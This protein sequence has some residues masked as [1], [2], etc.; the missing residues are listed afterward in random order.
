MN[1]T[2]KE[3]GRISEPDVREV[4]Q[5]A[6]T[7]DGILKC[8]WCGR[9]YKYQAIPTECLSAFACLPG[10]DKITRRTV[11]ATRKCEI[12]WNGQKNIWKLVD[13]IAE[14]L[15]SEPPIKIN[16]KPMGPIEALGLPQ[17]IRHIKEQV[18][19]L[20]SDLL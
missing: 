9:P 8:S 14:A 11:P 1:I 18:A 5:F 2:K 15:G 13:P 16:D 17:K 7:T 4:E 12:E 6:F 20:Q 10:C 3:K 19:L